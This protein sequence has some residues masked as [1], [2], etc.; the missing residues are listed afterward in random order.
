M[1]L[2]ITKAA[3]E[4]HINVGL[5]KLKPNLEQL[6]RIAFNQPQQ[7]PVEFRVAVVESPLALFHLEIEGPR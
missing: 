1:H 7:L 5:E 6:K 4:F 3:E 2:L